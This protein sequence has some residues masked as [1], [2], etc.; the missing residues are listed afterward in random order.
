MVD[1]PSA[2]SVND[3]EE[4]LEKA[5][6]SPSK[7]PR[8]ISPAARAAG[9]HLKPKPASGRAAG[10]PRPKSAAGARWNKLAGSVSE[11]ASNPNRPWAK[12]L[13]EERRKATEKSARIEDRKTMNL[14]KL[15]VVIRVRPMCSRDVSAK[16]VD[17][18]PRIGPWISIA[19]PKGE[20]GPRLQFTTAVLG[21]ESSQRDAFVECAMP[22]LEAALGGQHSCLF[23]YGETG[24]GKTFSMLGAEGGRCPSKLDGI[25]PQ[26][27]AELFRRF[28]SQTRQ[29]EREYQIHATYVEI[30]AHR[31]YDLLAADVKGVPAGGRALPELS[32]RESSDGDFIVVGAATERIHSAAGLTTLVEKAAGRRATSVNDAHNHSSRS[33]AFLTLHLERRTMEGGGERRQTT[34]FHLVDLAGSENFSAVSAAAA[35][36]NGGLLALGKVLM[37]CIASPNPDPDPTLTGTPALC[38]DSNITQTSCSVA[39]L[40]CRTVAVAVSILNPNPAIPDKPNPN[41]N[42]NQV[43]MALA[44]DKPAPHVPYRDATLTKMLK[45]VLTGNCLN[46]MLACINPTADGAAESQNTLRYAQQACCV[47]NQTRTQTFEEMIGDDPLRDDCFD[48]NEELNCRTEA[49]QTPSHGELVA[50]VAGDPGEPLVLYLHGAGAGADSGAWN[51]L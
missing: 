13:V 15:K 11:P 44:S 32:L 38:V 39:L 51:E 37:A 43:L 30:F 25:V 23:A 6:L 21:G 14:S 29:G 34:R 22:L 47:L 40:Q 7:E 20:S 5:S 1:A 3:I 35:S 4:Q 49:V 45:Q 48:P 2:W 46:L 50:R 31:V 41:P 36:I 12:G 42:P 10:A 24:S 8:P 27:C 9:S 28:A 19:D 33:H 18:E 17:C 16:A 26:L